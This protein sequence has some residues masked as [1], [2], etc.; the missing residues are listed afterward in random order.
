FSNGPR[1]LTESRCLNSTLDAGFEHDLF[2]HAY[3]HDRP[4]TRET[5][6]DEFIAANRAQLLHHCVKCADAWDQQS[7]R[8][9][10]LARIPRQGR[11][12]TRVREGLQ[13]GV[14]IARAVVEDCDAFFAHRAPFVEG[15]PVSEGSYAFALRNAR[16]NALNSASA[17]WW[18]SR[19]S[20]SLTCTVRRAF[21]TNASKK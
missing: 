3:P 6:V 17:M 20:T 1:P 18:G 19:P 21:N 8:P 16:A 5:A 13:H 12:R 4:P 10:D 11:Y 15:I 14:H 9:I 7:V 2:T